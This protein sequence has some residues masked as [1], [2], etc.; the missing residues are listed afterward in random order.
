MRGVSQP[1]PTEFRALVARLNARL[2]HRL[3]AERN[4]DRRA[5]IAMFPGQIASLEQ[6]LVEFLQAAFGGS[7]SDPAPLLRGAYLTSGTRR[8]HRSID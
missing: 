8:A 5:L 7:P 2:F 3:H 1:S 6:R 4:P